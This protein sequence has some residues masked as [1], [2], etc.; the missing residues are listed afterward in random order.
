[1]LNTKY[2]LS[3]FRDVLGQS[4][5]FPKEKMFLS[6]NDIEFLE[7]ERCLKSISTTEGPIGQYLVEFDKKQLSVF[8]T[9]H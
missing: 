6:D 8:V 7:K 2:L 9:V 1:M 3:R 5:D 4:I